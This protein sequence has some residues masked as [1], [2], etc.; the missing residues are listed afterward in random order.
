MV[1]KYVQ[2]KLDVSQITYLHEVNVCELKIEFTDYWRVLDRRSS[3]KILRLFSSKP[4]KAPY[5]QMK[6]N[7]DRFI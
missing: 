4:F 2:I 5:L 7:S 6:E 1:L 3:L